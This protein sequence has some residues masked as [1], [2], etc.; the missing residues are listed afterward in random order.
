[1]SIATTACCSKTVDPDVQ[2]FAEFHSAK[3]PL[4]G[5]FV[6]RFQTE[7][8][9]YVYD[10]NS[11]RVFRVSD[12]AYDIVEDCAEDGWDRL[13]DKYPQYSARQLRRCFREMAAAR[14]REGILRC[15]RPRRMA[16]GG[17]LDPHVLLATHG[18]EQL[19]LNITERCNLRCRYCTYS[20]LY[21]HHRRHGTKDMPPEVAHKAIDHFLANLGE[22]PCLSFYGGEPLLRLD[23][24]QDLVAYAEARTPRPLSYAITTNGI[25][26]DEPA[27]AYLRA[28]GFGVLVSLDGPPEIHDRYRVDGGGRGSFARVVAN[29][30]PFRAADEQYYRQH[31]GFSVVSAP[32]YHVGAVDDFF[33]TH[34]VTRDCRVAFSF[35]APG[36]AGSFEPPSDPAPQEVSPQ[37]EEDDLQRQFFHQVQ[38][39]T[40]V[41]GLKQAMFERDFVRFFHRPKTPLGEELPLNGCCVP[42]ARRLFVTVEGMLFACERV[43]QRYPLGTVDTWVA[44]LLLQRL[45]YDYVIAGQDCF[46]C[47]A[48]RLC[49]ECFS[50]RRIGAAPD[51][52][53]LADCR[54]TRDRLH[55][56][57]VD[58]YR[59]FEEQEDAWEYLQ[60]VEIR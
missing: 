1:M 6:H 23:L 15:D 12:L 18:H 57:L 8:G 32:P 50:T 11:N 51:A 21:A 54:Q 35:M 41:G 45:L 37:R 2:P 47:W 29:L 17:T 26:L 10:V 5:P 59:V 52:E 48:C 4:P 55:R 33:Q 31:V 13:V 44:P 14:K 9:K 38:A 25:L 53:R 3:P 7:R 58:Y 49:T 28:K 20:G 19:I 34:P 42:G 22:E 30:E 27:R 16:F 46:Q 60:E 56:L 39:H 36:Y 40:R 43:D 24:I